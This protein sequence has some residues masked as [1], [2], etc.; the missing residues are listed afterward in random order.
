MQYK[1]ELHMHTNLV[2]PC[3]DLPFEEA[4]ERY[5]A[6]GYTSLVVTDHYYRPIVERD[7]LSWEETVEHYLSGYR[8]MKEYLKGRM[9]V[10]LG[11]ELRFLENLNDYLVFGITEEFLLAHPHLHRMTLKDFSALSRENGFLLVQA[12]PFRTRMTV[13]DPALLDGME[14][15]NGHAGHRSRN[16]L[17]LEQAKRNGL[18]PTSGSDFHHPDSVIA[19]GILTDAPIT[20]SEQL[21]AVLRSRDYTLVCSGPCAERDGMQSMRADGI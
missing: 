19:G 11:C 3:A 8:A 10:I 7:G 18:I 14:V 4:A 1:T 6:A 15:F 2:S 20:S 21:L 17:A 9:H 12:H 16:F 13:V 5:V